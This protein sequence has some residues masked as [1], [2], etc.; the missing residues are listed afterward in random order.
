MSGCTGTVSCNCS[1][2]GQIRRSAYR[3]GLADAAVVFRRTDRPD[4]AVVVEA[5]M[6]ELLLPEIERL[7]WSEE[8]TRLWGTDHV[9]P[10]C[11]GRRIMGHA[12]DCAL[13]ELLRLA[14]VASVQ[15]DL[16]GVH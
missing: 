1:R 5:R 12:E 14:R 13:L 6:L 3:D 8:V 2:C 16:F 11:Q 4:P 7:E 9:C 15:P 10:E